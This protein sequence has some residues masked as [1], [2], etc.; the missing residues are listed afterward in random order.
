MSEIRKR[1]AIVGGGIGGLAMA[2]ALSHLKVDEHLQIDIYESTGKLTQIGA[3]IMIWPRGWEIIQSLGLEASLAQKMS[4]DQELPSPEQLKPTFKIRKGDTKEDR[5]I[6]DVMMPG[7]SVA[8]H[9]ADVQEV[10][11]KHISPSIKVHLSHRLISYRELEEGLVELEFKNGNKV[12]C[13]LLIGADGINSA[14]RKTFLR[15]KN[16]WSEEE[17][18]QKAQPLWTG[19]T[20]YRNTIDAEL[21]RKDSPNHRALTE[22]VM[23]LV[24]YP[25]LQGKLV[26]AVPF[27]TNYA[28]EGTYVDGPVLVEGSKD[29]FAPNFA[30]WAD[31]VEV[32][33]KHMSNPSRWE[34]QH[35]SPLDT[36]V[37]ESGSVVLLGDAAH[38][39]P[40]HL[41]NGASQ[42]I[43]DV[44]VLA[45]VLAKGIT[46]GNFDIPRLTKIYDTV[47]QPFAVFAA[48]ASVRL[49]YLLDLHSPGFENIKDGDEVSQESVDTLAKAI[50]DVWAWT[51]QSAKPDMERALAMV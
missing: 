36:Y 50:Q 5:H 40:P 14:I 42:A 1:V 47:R 39:A 7:G 2:V 27:L 41:G 17:A 51:W 24:A 20:V 38:A 48:D 22:A 23:H 15:N 16:G 10:L 44:Y 13:D 21:I 26:N 35:H 12:T 29:N 46:S 8:F 9:R 43:E 18:A 6:I 11:L 30:G 31:D 33:I 45:N 34:I 4:P 3:G 37:S 32:L 25:I 28:R 49:G 19:S